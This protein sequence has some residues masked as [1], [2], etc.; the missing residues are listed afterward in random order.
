M[1]SH[2]V[3]LNEINGHSFHKV[4]INTMLIRKL[5]DVSLYIFLTHSV[6]FSSTFMVCFYFFFWHVPLFSSLPFFVSPNLLI[7]YDIILYFSPTCSLFSATFSESSLFLFYDVY[8]A[9]LLV[10][11]YLT[12]SARPIYFILC[13]FLTVHS[14]LGA[15][16]AFPPSLI[17]PYFLCQ[18]IEHEYQWL[19]VL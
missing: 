2:G 5:L 1:S 6:F 3:P 8:P 15:Y 10:Y 4:T 9:S 16:T 11:F 7:C 18:I 19:H 12:L 17:T 13:V 14:L